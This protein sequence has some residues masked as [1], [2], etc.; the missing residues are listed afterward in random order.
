[1]TQAVSAC[2]TLTRTIRDFALGPDVCSTK[3]T[4]P[5][6]FDV[7]A[8]DPGEQRTDGY[9]SDEK[10]YLR[11]NRSPL[12]IP[13]TMLLSSHLTPFLFFAAELARRTKLHM[14]Q[15]AVDAA[16]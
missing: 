4:E 9:H 8:D 10:G 14:A 12:P 11:E 1:M 5:I 15:P 3:V 16:K 2:Q 7:D 13:V 6:Q